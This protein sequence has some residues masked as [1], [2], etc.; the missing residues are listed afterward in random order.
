M[1]SIGGGNDKK[2]VDGDTEDVGA[3][4]AEQPDSPKADKPNNEAAVGESRSRKRK[5]LHASLADDSSS[6]SNVAVSTIL[7]YALE[8]QLF[9]DSQTTKSWLAANSFLA[10]VSEP[11][12]VIGRCLWESTL[13]HH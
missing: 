10:I 7:Y 9:A 8:S 12:M 11:S 4:N 13:V 6:S 5:I 1:N 3:L 2:S